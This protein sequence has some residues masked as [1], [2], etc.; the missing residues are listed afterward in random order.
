MSVSATL[1]VNANIT[2]YSIGINTFKGNRLATITVVLAKKYHVAPSVITSWKEELLQDSSKVVRNISKS[3]NNY[4][5]S[6]E[7]PILERA[8]IEKSSSN[9]LSHLGMRYVVYFA[10]NFVMIIP[11]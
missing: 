8:S 7:L 5:C 1:N 3:T 4:N 10:C 11:F 9:R 6:N 2:S